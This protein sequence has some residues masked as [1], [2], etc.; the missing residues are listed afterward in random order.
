M[1]WERRG[2]NPGRS[3]VGDV[4]FPDFKADLINPSIEGDEFSLF[5]HKE[6]FMFRFLPTRIL[7][8][9]ALVFFLV[10]FSGCTS[11]RSIIVEPS[12][13]PL[14]N[15]STLEVLDCGSNVQEEHALNLAKEFPNL[16]VTK[17][18]EFNKGHSSSP[19]FANVIRSTDETGR[20]L[21]MKSVLLS[22]EKG[23]KAARYFIGFGSGKASCMVQC[24]FIDKG[25]GEQVLKANFEGEL[26][27][28]VLGGTSKQAAGKVLD[29]IVSFL[30][31]N[32]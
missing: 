24:T 13:V 9:A 14:K 11:G 10:G 32:Y 29:Q 22:Y 21:Q 12:T 16:V 17:L 27:M 30:R 3:S 26:S 20:V 1:A 25:T 5:F 6:G 18:V 4:E 7:V 2:G 31:K 28:G 23:S 15:F 8:F 19:L